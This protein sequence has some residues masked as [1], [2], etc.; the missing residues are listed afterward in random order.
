MV[1]G[2]QCRCQCRD[3]GIYEEVEV[4]VQV[5]MGS[6]EPVMTFGGL[7]FLGSAVVQPTLLTIKVSANRGAWHMQCNMNHITSHH[8]AV[9]IT[10]TR[11]THIHNA[12]HSSGSERTSCPSRDN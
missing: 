10:Y 3:N 1:R 2:R 5:Q 8:V 4:Q 11:C 6:T 9:G 12:S 7:R